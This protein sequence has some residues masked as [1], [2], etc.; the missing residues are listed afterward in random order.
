VALFDD[1]KKG[2]SG[3][4]GEASKQVDIARLNYDID[5]LKSQLAEVEAEAGRRVHDMWRVGRVK[6]EDLVLLCERMKAIHAEINGLRQQIEAGKA[7]PAVPTCPTCQ[8]AV[9]REA[10]F[11]P[12]CG[13]R[14]EPAPET[15]PQP[16]SP[17]TPQTPPT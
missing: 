1:I 17:Q 6:D 2:L 13:T 11:C 14:V 9:P 12:N 16:A 4:A 3:L 10:Q 15:P 8:Q 7:A 5:R